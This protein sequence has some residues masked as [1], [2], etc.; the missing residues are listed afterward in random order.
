MGKRATE[1]H[2]T[3]DTIFFLWY[4]LFMSG[5]VL[6]LLFQPAFGTRNRNIAKSLSFLGRRFMLDIP[7]RRPSRPVTPTNFILGNCIH[8]LR[9][10]WLGAVIIVCRPM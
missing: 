5:H 1:V 8:F 4:L 2:T 9:L 10:P 6:L 7:A 3:G